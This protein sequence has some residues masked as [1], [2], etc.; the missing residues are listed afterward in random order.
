MTKPK[1]SRFLRIAGLCG[2]I[3]PILSLALI[4]YAVAISPWFSW[5]TNALSDLGA[6]PRPSAL[7]FNVALIS[8]GVLTAILV[9][10]MGQ[11]VGPGWLG[12]AGTVVSLV[13]AVALGL[14]G[15]FPESYLGLHWAVAATY[16]LVTPVG[17]ALLGAQIWR[18]GRRAHGAA[19]ISAAV[20]AFLAIA[21][22][23]HHGLA[24]PELV[25]ALLLTSRAF[26]MGMKLWL[27][28]EGGTV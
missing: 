23:P 11:W 12:R 21:F 10:G 19:A 8:G 26:S 20:G 14:I 9:L 24:V 27:D 6:Y 16:F 3:A 2:V 5:Q 1:N 17:Y 13:G 7:P 15:V 4:F 25:A 28:N 18:S 22:I